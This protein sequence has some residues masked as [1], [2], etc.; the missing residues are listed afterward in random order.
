[1]K[2]IL[3]AARSVAPL[4]VAIILTLIFPDSYAFG[5][6]KITIKTIPE[7]ANIHI[8]GQFVGNGTYTVKFDKNNEFYVV[9]VTANGYVGRRYRLLKSNPQK[10]V[11]YSLPV[12]EALEASVGSENGM[13]LAN[14]WKDIVCREG[15][16]ESVIWKRLMSVC[17]NYFDDIE[18]RDKAAGWIKTGW[19]HTYFT[20]QVVRTRLEVRMS[21]ID[22]NTISFRARIASEIRDRECNRENCYETYPRVMKAFEPMINE[23]QTVVG[24]GI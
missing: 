19:K 1:M 12:D 2:K 16:E 24:G 13:D 23:L 10:T 15:M 20:N 5:A 21:F 14:K 11:I 22:E 9:S 6:K 17:T 8:D 7:N 4:L 3:T 18:V